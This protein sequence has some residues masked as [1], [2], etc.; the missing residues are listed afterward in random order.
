MCHC[1]CSLLLSISSVPS[2]PLDLTVRCTGPNSINITWSAPAD[3]NG[4]LLRYNVYAYIENGLVQEKY[5]VIADPAIMYNSFSITNL[6]PN[7]HYM[8][9][10]SA[11]THIGEGARTVSYNVFTGQT[12]VYMEVLLR[13]NPPLF[14]V[15]TVNS[16]SIKL[17]WKSTTVD[18]LS[19]PGVGY[20]IYH[21][22]TS[23]GQ[24]NVDP[25]VINNPDSR[26]HV[27]QGLMPFTYYKFSFS[28]Y[29][30]FENNNIY[31]TKSSD[32]VVA[33]TDE[34]CKI[35]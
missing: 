19:F 30:I 4:I 1:I 20:I 21:N 12:I 15:E 33:R 34:D 31:C 17:S 25:S 5:E 22:V 23:E 2:A 27:F 32:S 14:C 3:A 35:L 18:D 26:T 24:Q 28:E 7:L 8:F 9:E 10:V 29:A 16:T 13:Y 6:A 11:E